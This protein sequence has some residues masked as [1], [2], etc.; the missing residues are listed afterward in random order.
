ML[1]DA[2]EAD[3]HALKD[4]LESA[5]N[6][7]LGYKVSVFLRRPAELAAIAVYAAF[8]A[9]ELESA[10][11]LNVAFLSAAPDEE[12]QRKLMALKTDIDD[13]H[14]HGRQVYWLCRKRQSESTFSNAALERALGQPSTLRGIKTIRKMVKKYD[15]EALMEANF[16]AKASIEVQAPASKVWEALTR[17]ELI[18]QYLFGT[19]VVT[20]WQAGSPIMYKGVWQGKPY[21]DKGKVLQVE[22][23]KLL[24]STFWSSLSGEADIPENYKTVRYELSATGGGTTLTILQDNNAS[25]EEAEHSEQNWKLVLEG[26][27]KLLE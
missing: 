12:A 22:P 15:L 7:A 4:H 20:D 18:Q 9:G 25:Q 5:L 27:K 1:F 26:I 13:F 17:P 8:K 19:Q 11:A 16:I 3:A 21:E 10:A 24:V 14:V 6:E 23:G 2:P